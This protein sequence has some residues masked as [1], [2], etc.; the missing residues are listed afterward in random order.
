LWSEVRFSPCSI[1]PYFALRIA[2]TWAF[3]PVWSCLPFAASFLVL[4]GGALYSVG[5]ILYLWERL[6]FQNE[7]WHCFVLLDAP[8]TDFGIV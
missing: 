4:G 5:V 8:C 6:R 7:I 1:L 3:T 2:G